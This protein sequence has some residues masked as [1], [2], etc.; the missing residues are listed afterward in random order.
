MSYQSN[1]VYGV[2]R[3]PCLTDPWEKRPV[4]V[5]MP[6]TQPPPRI[7]PY[8]RN[9]LIR[10]LTQVVTR[11]RSEGYGGQIRERRKEEREERTPTLF[12]FECRRSA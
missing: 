3:R 9:Y 8:V 7:D 10:L 6:V 12:R 4:A 11:K 5:G 2:K 1:L